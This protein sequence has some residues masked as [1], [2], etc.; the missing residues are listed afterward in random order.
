RQRHRRRQQRRRQRH[1]RRPAERRYRRNGYRLRRRCRDCRCRRHVL[2]EEKEESGR[3]AAKVGYGGDHF[4]HA[5]RVRQTVAA[6]RRRRRRPLPW[7][8]R[9]GSGT[10]ARPKECFSVFVVAVCR[11]DGGSCSKG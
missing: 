7:W 8:V 11:D 10:A 6:A 2:R 5:A 1:K 9:E 4:P 3:S